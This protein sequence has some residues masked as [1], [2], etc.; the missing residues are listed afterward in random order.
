M[1]SSRWEEMKNLFIY[2]FSKICIGIFLY[3][4]YTNTTVSY[5]GS[6]ATVI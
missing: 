4:N 2:T 3:K 5:A 1:Y 6:I